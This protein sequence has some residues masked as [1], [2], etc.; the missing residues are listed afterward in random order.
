MNAN[1]ALSA[2]Q[3]IFMVVVVITSLATWLT[4]MFLAA[5]QPRGP[6]RAVRPREE[7]AGPAATG[8]PPEAG[9]L[10]S[11]MIRHDARRRDDKLDY[12]AA[13]GRGFGVAG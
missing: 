7:Q 6:S 11:G 3:L 8:P 5:R 12:Q 4:A 2:G 1:S 9:G 10:P 13:A